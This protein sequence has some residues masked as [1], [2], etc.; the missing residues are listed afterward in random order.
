MY[1]S[2]L[3]AASCGVVAQATA[4]SY[5]HQ[6]FLLNEGYFNFNTQTQEVPVSL[7]S[8]DPATGVYQ[9][10]AT[11]TG[12][13]FGSDVDLANG[14]VYVA[15]DG[16]LLKYDADTYSMLD[17][18]AV[19]GIRKI[20]LW[21][22]QVLITRGEL[23]GLDHYFEVR[24]VATLDLLYSIEPADG[25]LYSAEDVEVAGDKAYLAVG[26]AF[27]F[28]NMVGLVG[29]V[30]LPSA[31]YENEV[32][33]GPNGINPE[34]IMVVGQ[35]LYVL[36]NKDFSG[37]SISKVTTGGAFAF[38]EDITENSGC[39]ASELVADKVVYNEYALSRMARYD[40]TTENVLDTL[41]TTLFPYGLLNDALN[42]V[43]Y[44]TTTDFVS[45]GTLHVLDH[46]GTE[47]SSTAIGVSAGR[48]CLDVR[49]STATPER[50][51]QSALT[52]FPVPTSD[53]VT[54]SMPLRSVG[55]VRVR[56]AAG[57]EV[58][59]ITPTNNTMD[60]DLGAL[61]PGVYS[62]QVPGLPA[63]RIVKR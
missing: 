16:A 36:C 9:T 14:T 21:N 45:S 35:D 41:A 7:G 61:E 6:V 49:T 34:N 46:D 17:Q 55:P 28:G 37:S 22:D 57:R 42:N 51:P 12:Q 18:A 10:V 1:R 52:I 33:L 50:A 47:L 43:I 62:V 26:N 2:L 39:G 13:R 8:Y 30:D 60:L 20:A 44:A 32:D 48:L 29:I 15:A 59:R 53:R 4:Q 23:G 63:A 19:P 38:T 5:V 11:I 40:I 58:L 25:L 54:V 56:D 27:D 31:T 3:F 24:D